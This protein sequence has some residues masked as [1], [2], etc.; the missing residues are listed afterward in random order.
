MQT[1]FAIRYCNNVYYTA[2]LVEP[3]QWSRHALLLLLLLYIFVHRTRM[4][5]AGKSK[6]CELA[7][8]TSWT[9]DDLKFLKIIET[10][11]NL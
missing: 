5:I 9:V 10:G 8:S 1:S 4:P 6:D 3:P 11:K 7:K 2:L